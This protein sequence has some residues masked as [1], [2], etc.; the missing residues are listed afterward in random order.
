[1]NHPLDHN[2]Y[3]FY[4]MRYQ[5]DIDPQTE[6][7]TGRFLSVFQV[8]TN[9]GRPIIYAGCLLVVLGTAVQFYMRA[10]V[11]DLFTAAARMERERAAAKARAAEAKAHEAAQNERRRARASLI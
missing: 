10:G 7:P 8:A 1:M 9:P 3:T 11:C 4:Q 5:P 2:G 6:R